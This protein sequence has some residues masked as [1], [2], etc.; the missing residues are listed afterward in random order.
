MNEPLIFRC[1]VD[2]HLCFVYSDVLLTIKD[3]NIEVIGGKNI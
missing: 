3:D 2:K 1:L